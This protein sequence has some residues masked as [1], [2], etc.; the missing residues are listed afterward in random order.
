MFVDNL[1]G[2]AGPDGRRNMA[3]RAHNFGLIGREFMLVRH[4]HAGQEEENDRSSNHAA[5]ARQYYH[6]PGDKDCHS[7]SAGILPRQTSREKS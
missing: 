7:A 1:S 4:Q 6:H 3:H 2:A 5:N